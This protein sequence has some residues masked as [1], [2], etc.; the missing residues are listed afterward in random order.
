M[1]IIKLARLKNEWEYPYESNKTD[2]KIMSGYLKYLFR[3]HV[4]YDSN[5]I[6]I[7]SAIYYTLSYFL[8][9]N[10]RIY[11]KIKIYNSFIHGNK[12]LM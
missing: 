1:T 11:W 12:Y 8:Y 6:F 4:I 3:P 10:N 2:D 5:I 9:N 7:H